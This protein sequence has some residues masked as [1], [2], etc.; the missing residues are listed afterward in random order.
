MIIAMVIHGL[1]GAECF[2]LHYNNDSQLVEI[3]LKACS[4]EAK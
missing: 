3:C 4:K 2:C 1:T